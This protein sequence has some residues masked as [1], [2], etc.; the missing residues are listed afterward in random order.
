MIA[1]RWETKF[2]WFMTYLIDW[3]NDSFKTNSITK[4]FMKTS[5]KIPNC[6]ITFFRLLSLVFISFLVRIFSASSSSAVLSLGAF[7][8]PGIAAPG[9][10]YLLPVKG[11]ES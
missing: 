6:I 5:A 7:G 1:F 3:T 9:T 10:G 4:L 11:L 2:K 8:F